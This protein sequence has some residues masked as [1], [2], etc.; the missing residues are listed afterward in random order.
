MLIN[1][2]VYLQIYQTGASMG[3]GEAI[4]TSLAEVGANLI[5]FS[6][7]EVGKPVYAKVVSSGC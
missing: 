7:S 1:T 2:D 6:R 3:I 5:L 4:A